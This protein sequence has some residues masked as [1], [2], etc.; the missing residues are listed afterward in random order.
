MKEQDGIWAVV[1]PLQGQDDAAAVH[2]DE[3]ARRRPPGSS[4]GSWP[5][6]LCL[7][8]REKIGASR[9]LESFLEIW[10]TENSSACINSLGRTGGSKNC[11]S[12]EKTCVFPRLGIKSEEDPRDLLCPRC[13]GVM[14]TKCIDCAT[15]CQ[16]IKRWIRKRQKTK[17][18]IKKGQIS[19]CW[20]NKN[21]DCYKR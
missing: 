10:S 12:W 16:I 5:P 13:P 15:N 20:M 17:C 4:S 3:G 18:W 6:E 9:I 7:L 1:G 14:G 8:G 21:A 19:K 11:L 2:T